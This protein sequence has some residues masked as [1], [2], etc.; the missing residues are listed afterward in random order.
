MTVSGGKV[1]H[2]IL[3]ALNSLFFFL[4]TSLLVVGAGTDPQPRDPS[5]LSPFTPWW[6]ETEPLTSESGR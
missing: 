1:H 2:L 6:P 4:L 3:P 5:S